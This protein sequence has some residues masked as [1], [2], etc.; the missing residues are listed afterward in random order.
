VDTKTRRTDPVFVVVGNAILPGIGYLAQRRLKAAAIAAAGVAILLL[1]LI[2]E[3]GTRLWPVLLGV[4]WAGIVLHSLWSCRSSLKELIHGWRMSTSLWAARISVLALAGIMMCAAYFIRTDA[5]QTLEAASQVHR[6]G[7]CDEATAILNELTTAHRIA[8][9]DTAGK[10]A[11]Q[12]A[13]CELLADID[14]E[15]TAP[16]EVIDALEH[17]LAH[18]GHR[19]KAAGLHRAELLLELATTEDSLSGH[20]EAAFFQLESTL[21]DDPSLTREVATL[22]AS[23]TAGFDQELP[24]CDLLDINQWVAAEESEQ[25]ALAEAIADATVRVPALM[26]D[27]ARVKVGELAYDEGILLY[28]EFLEAYPEH[29]LAGFA[30]EELSAA[31]AALALVREVEE[32][33]AY[34]SS[35]NDYCSEPVAF[36]QAPQYEGVASESVWL[37]GSEEIESA[38]PEAWTTTSAVDATAVVCVTGPEEGSYLESC[39]YLFFGGDDD[40]VDAHANEFQ[41]EVFEL[42]T[43][44]RVASLAGE[45]GD[46]CPDEI[47][48]YIGAPLP[49]TTP[50]PYS[51]ADLRALFNRLL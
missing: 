18:P 27:C 38:F 41:V 17:Y 15:E 28:R 25:E 46:H 11:D 39:E 33:Q 44:E 5:E 14:N 51:E 24:T 7:D 45:V 34:L 2:Q 10:A 22:L 6:A 8:A 29:E 9:N 50:A 30:Q 23:F 19:W 31:E 43:G 1:P 48:T 40:V 26:I 13:A 49:E 16:Q 4:W 12:I 35:G 3:P 36:S 32:V 20:A 42:R 21:R 47:E 37:F